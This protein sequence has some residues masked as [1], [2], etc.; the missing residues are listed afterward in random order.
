MTILLATVGL[1]LCAQAL[2]GCY[3]C[4]QKAFENRVQAH[5][6][7]GMPM[8]AAI[9]KLAD[10]RLICSSGNPA[11]CSRIRQSLLPYSC[12]ERV[13]LHWMKSTQQVTKIEIPEIAC[14]GL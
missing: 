13:R 7:V 12:V 6:A 1:A 2:T 11:E 4:N 9:A 14:A 3:V 10:M 8:Q 5:I